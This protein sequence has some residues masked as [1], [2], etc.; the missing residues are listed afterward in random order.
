MN[1][2]SIT[3]VSC[4]VATSSLES[5]PCDGEKSNQPERLLFLKYGYGKISVKH[6]FLHSAEVV[7]VNLYWEDGC[8]GKTGAF[9]KHKSSSL[10]NQA[11]EVI[12]S[13]PRSDCDT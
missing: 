3:A 13:L 4:S 10:H 6:A 9:C 8:S 1:V 2:T 11:V 7:F 5:L 12:Y